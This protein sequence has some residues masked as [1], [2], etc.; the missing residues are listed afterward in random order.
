M[1]PIVVALGVFIFL[2]LLGIGVIKHLIYICAPNEV[3]IF[4]G[5]RR[6][7]SGRSYGYRLIKGGRGV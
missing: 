5:S 7:D 4:S 2:V 1:S 3:L 6:T